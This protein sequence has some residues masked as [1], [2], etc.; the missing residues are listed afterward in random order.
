MEQIQQVLNYFSTYFTSG[1]ETFVIPWDQL[2]YPCVIEVCHL[3]LEPLCDTHL[4]LSVILKTLM[5]TGQ[6]FLEVTP[7]TLLCVLVSA[8]LACTWRIIFLNRCSWPFCATRSG[9]LLLTQLTMNFDRHCALC[10]KKCYHT[11]HFTVCRS[12]NKSFLFN[13]SMMLLWELWKSC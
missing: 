3:G 6:K 1:I 2:L 8:V 4:C 12:W 9:K 5:L 10:I 11:P 7:S 13:L